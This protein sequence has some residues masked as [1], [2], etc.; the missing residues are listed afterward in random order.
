MH[1]TRF[2]KIQLVIFTVLSAVAASV[3]AVGYMDLPAKMF[4]IGRYI[5]V[6]DLARS[7][8]LYERANVTYRGTEV[9]HVER[10]TGERPDLD[11]LDLADPAVYRMVC[12]ADTLGRLLTMVMHEQEMPLSSVRADLP[13]GF[14]H[15]VAR[16]LQKDPE[17]R[18]ANVAELAYALIPFS[19]DPIRARSTA[20]RIAAVLSLPMLP[21]ITGDMSGPLPMFSSSRDARVSTPP[22]ANDTG[23]AAPWAGTQGG[24][25]AKSSA[26][27]I[28]LGVAL[29]ALLVGSG[30]FAKV[31]R[32]EQAEARA[33]AASA[34]PIVPLP[35]VH[36]TEPAPAPAPTPLAMSASSLEQGEAPTVIGASPSTPPPPST[37]TPRAESTPSTRR[38]PA[39]ST[40]SRAKPTAPSRP[41]IAAPAPPRNESG[42]P[43]TRD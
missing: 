18:F 40:P 32:D 21:P 39:P 38:A 25:R 11:A 43:D 41:V 9:G 34:A 27:T 14:E 19:L 17:A 28:W 35:T 22:G 42:I 30:I 3:M 10:V 4:G 29:A 31:H 24:G 36:P 2:V 5:V 20:D 23:T 13:P 7:G 1:L 15:V 8:G 16:C 6:V 26:T 12:A 37:G 33:R